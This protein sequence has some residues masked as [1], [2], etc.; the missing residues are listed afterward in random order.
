[1]ELEYKYLAWFIITTIVVIRKRERGQEAVERYV[2]TF[3]IFAIIDGLIY[4]INNKK[5][6]FPKTVQDFINDCQK[7]GIILEIKD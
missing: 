1:M 4:Y 5:Y 2:F 3:I 6:P 7:E